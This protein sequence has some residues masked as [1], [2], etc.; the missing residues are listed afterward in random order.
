MTDPVRWLHCKW[1]DPPDGQSMVGDVSDLCRADRVRSIRYGGW[2]RVGSEPDL[3]RRGD[4]QRHD[5]LRG[6]EIHIGGKYYRG[7]MRPAEGVTGSG[8]HAPRH[9][10]PRQYVRVSLGYHTG[11]L[12]QYRVTA[13][14]TSGYQALTGHLPGTGRHQTINIAYN[15]VAAV[16]MDKRTHVSLIL[17]ENFH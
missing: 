9:R 13:Y 16:C 6:G 8:R 11:H 14:R 15:A 2:I 1:V 12:M 5:G 4:I 3:G 7:L 17:S 10:R